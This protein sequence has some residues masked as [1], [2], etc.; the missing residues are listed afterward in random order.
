M[1]REVAHMEVLELAEQLVGE[2]LWVILGQLQLV[3][4]YAH[5]CYKTWQCD[6]TS[7]MYMHVGTL[8]GKAYVPLYL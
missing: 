7:I 2:C 4:L 5:G 6:L 1:L 3:S 8:W